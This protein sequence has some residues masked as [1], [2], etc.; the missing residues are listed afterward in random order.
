[1]AG[2]FE[3]F[4]LGRDLEMEK[5]KEIYRLFRKH[6]FRLAGLRSFGRYVTEEELAAKQAMA[7][8]LRNEP[9]LFEVVKAEASARLAKIPPRS[10]GVSNGTNGNGGGWKTAMRSMF[11]L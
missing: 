6:G 3:S 2:R 10:K 7:D 11:G 8:V 5:V 1:M 9:E 4:T